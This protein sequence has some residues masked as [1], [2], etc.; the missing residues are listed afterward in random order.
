MA[1]QAEL[2]SG[3]ARTLM[4]TRHPS[5]KDSS[6]LGKFREGHPR[7]GLAGEEAFSRL[8]SKAERVSAKEIVLRP[9]RTA[10]RVL[11]RPCSFFDGEGLLWRAEVPR[12]PRHMPDLHHL[13]AFFSF[14]WPPVT[15]P[16]LPCPPLPEWG[17]FRRVPPHY[18]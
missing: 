6:L 3:S 12:P 9:R 14:L 15:H 5:D 4:W 7:M 8:V 18:H 11:W 1:E 2:Q 17:P 16:S 10:Q 13:E